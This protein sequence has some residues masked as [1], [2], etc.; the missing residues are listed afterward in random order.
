LGKTRWAVVGSGA[1]AV[2]AIAALNARGI[3]PT[4]F[5]CSANQAPVTSQVPT[6]AGRMKGHL[7]SH[8]AYRMLPGDDNQ[9]P[10][11]TLARPSRYFGGFTR[12]WGGTFEFDRYLNRSFKHVNFDKDDFNLLASI[13]PT[14]T[15]Q[16]LSPAQISSPSQRRSRSVGDV[17][18]SLRRRSEFFGTEV[19]PTK[20]A[21]E[22]RAGYPNKCVGTGVCLTGCPNHAIWFAGDE[23]SRLAKANKIQLM[24]GHKV[25][26][27]S[28]KP[29]FISL[30]TI[31]RNT[32]QSF[33]F[34]KVV[35]AAG[36]LATA[37]IILRSTPVAAL[38]VRETLTAFGGIIAPRNIRRLENQPELANFSISASDG[39]SLAQVYP[40]SAEL[41]EEFIR[42]YPLLKSGARAVSHFSGHILPAVV[43]FSEDVSPTITT[44]LS[45]SGR[46]L[47]LQYEKPKTADLRDA[48]R[49]IRFLLAS[50]GYFLPWG[51]LEVP[52]S[53]S[54]FHFGASLP[55]GVSTDELGQLSGLRDV[56]IVDASVLPAI[57]VGSI[58]AITTLNASRII[59]MA[60]DDDS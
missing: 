50:N 18:V 30:S 31:S 36:P 17:S 41:G 49:P 2:A 51:G 10:K 58:T 1:S 26:G 60:V 53:G 14:T 20:I 52:G 8:D 55:M 40:P 59:R 47:T 6:F 25:T 37:E 29:E 44:R 35:L 21:V 57:E 54:G 22:S 39:S 9:I 12:V 34:D 45:D 13:V 5:E 56:H 32:S 11:G 48:L 7:G 23:I 3:A 4:V 24:M 28:R 46:G 33:S 42:R 43:Y 16:E 19:Q 27:L 38:K 15:S